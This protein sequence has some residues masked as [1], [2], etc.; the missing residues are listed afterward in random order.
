MSF[1]YITEILGWTSVIFYISITIFNSMKLTR[2]AVYG[3]AINDILWAILMG[4]WP[5]VILN[6]SVASL[7]TY[8]YI[9]DFTTASQVVILGMGGVMASGILYIT[10]FAVVAFIADPTLPVALQFADLGVILIALYMT[11]LSNYRKLMLLSGFIGMAA[12]FGNAQMM[13]IKLLVIGMMIYKL[14]FDK[15]NETIETTTA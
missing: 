1:K 9:K 11:T 3:S 4:W 7:N 6:I 10:Y 13:I 15:S 2:Y 14:F 5:K 8:R 12:Y